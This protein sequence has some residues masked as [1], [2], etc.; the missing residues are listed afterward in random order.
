VPIAPELSVTRGKVIAVKDRIVVFVPRGSNYELHLATSTQYTGPV[1]T[2]IEAVIR[3]V[4]RKIWTVATGGNFITPIIGPP[5]IVQGRVRHVTA[6]QIIV[7]AGAAF[8][9]DLPPVDS[10]IDL[11][12]GP[13]ALGSMVNVTA[14]PGAT[15]ELAFQPAAAGTA[16]AAV[17]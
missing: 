6:D 16:P 7:H 3:A 11:P 9:I 12:N 10:A 13:I 8:V 1:N 17:R 5:R 2:P 15:F 14:M 4:A